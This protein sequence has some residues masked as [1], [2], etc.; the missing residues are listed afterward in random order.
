M[1]GIT[2]DVKIWFP[3]DSYKYSKVDTYGRTSYWHQF[4]F[5]L[6]TISDASVVHHNELKHKKIPISNVCLA[7]CTV[8]LKG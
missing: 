2:F 8:C 5:P 3:K 7:G 4:N 1:P 6:R